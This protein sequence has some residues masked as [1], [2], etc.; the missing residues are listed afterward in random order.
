M[1]KESGADYLVN[2]MEVNPDDK[3]IDTL[4]AANVSQAGYF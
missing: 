2:P 3:V 1:A 4:S